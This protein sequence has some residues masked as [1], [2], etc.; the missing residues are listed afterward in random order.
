MIV[1][2]V[3]LAAAV[4][5]AGAQVQQGTIAGRILPAGAN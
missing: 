5:S 2:T 3:L 4:S 1:T